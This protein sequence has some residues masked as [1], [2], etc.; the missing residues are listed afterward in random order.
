MSLENNIRNNYTFM[1]A[2]EI[3]SMFNKFNIEK[4]IDSDL[5]TDELDHLEV[6]YDELECEKDTLERKV[7]RLDN[8]LD[9]AREDNIKLRDKY[10]KFRRRIRLK[11]MKKRETHMELNK[12]LAAKEND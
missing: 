1:E 7:Y 6:A 4:Y 8:Y 2:E 3:L 5:S 10:D 12:T 9:E 11:I